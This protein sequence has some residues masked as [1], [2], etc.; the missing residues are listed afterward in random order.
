MAASDPVPLGE[1]DIHV[2]RRTAARLAAEPGALRPHVNGGSRRPAALSASFH[3]GRT[4]SRTAGADRDAVILAALAGRLGVTFDADPHPTAPATGLADDDLVPLIR[5]LAS[6]APVGLLPLDPGSLR[7]RFAL[8]PERTGSRALVDLVTRAP[9]IGP[10][11]VLTTARGLDAAAAR[12]L[13]RLPPEIMHAALA[14]PPDARSALIDASADEDPVRAALLSG[15]LQLEDYLAALADLLDLPWASVAVTSLTVDVPEIAALLRP[16]DLRVETPD[17]PRVAVAADAVAPEALA[18]LLRRRPDLRAGLVLMS[19]RALRDAQ[20]VSHGPAILA[21]TA[22]A[23][24]RDRPDQSART[25]LTPAQGR[26]LVA[27]LALLA[28]G[29]ILAPGFLLVAGEIAAAAAFLSVASMRGGAALMGFAPRFAPARH[30]LARADLPTY[31]VLV[32]LHREADA[33]PGLVSA[34]R[35]LDYP[36]DRLDIK[37]LIEADDH[38]T[39]SAARRH[40]GSPPFDIL[41]I[42]P[43]GPRTKPKALGL[44][45]ALTKATLVTVFDAED[46][47]DPDQLRHAAE[48][49]AAAGPDLACVQGR[50]TIDHVAEGTWI[51]RLFGLDYAMHFDGLLPFLARHNLLFPLGGTSNHFRRASLNAVLGWDA[52]NVTEDADLAVRLVRAGYQMTVIRSST[53]EE[54]TETPRAWIRQRSRWF[55]GWLQ[56]WLVHMRAPRALLHDLGPRNFLAFQVLFPAS[57]IAVA[58][59]PVSL[60]LSCLYLAGLRGFGGTGL[61]DWLLF[62]LHFSTFTIGLGAAALLAITSL[63][64]RPLPLRPFDALLIV[65]YWLMM[66]IAL[67]WAVIDLI[68]R[69]HY[70]DKTEHARARRPDAPRPRPDPHPAPVATNRRDTRPPDDG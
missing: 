51:A 1:P 6:G 13:E 55:K 36:T 24:S 30:P 8:A 39:L 62:G 34:L 54:A 3:T 31:C 46:R 15:P 65:P 44:G 23:L 40:A 63:V 66:A 41:A 12:L 64:A 56:T 38:A 5:H 21:D 52:H 33:L 18:A 26:V 11:L 43:G 47:P 67:A 29:L 32:P 16:R 20:L 69:P 22:L 57:L 50:L 70:W 28:G 48:V 9:D 49:F 53:R 59:F 61:A 19:T 25:S 35:E 14:L 7:P 27:G 17:G 2:R 10:R 58:A 60:V 4:S 68:R 37:L 45:L 42:P